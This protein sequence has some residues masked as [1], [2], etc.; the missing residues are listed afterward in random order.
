MRMKKLLTLLLVLILSLSVLLTLVACGGGDGDG[1]N[2]G[3]NTANGGNPS[4]DNGGNTGGNTGGST[5]G[6]DNGGST[7][8]EGGGSTGGEGGS[9]GGGSEGGTDYSEFL[10]EDGELILFNSGM[11]TFKF[12]VA[13]DAA[14]VRQDVDTLASTLSGL[15]T[16]TVKVENAASSTVE[17]VEILIG[18]VNNR[19]DEYKYNKYDLGMQGYVVK[20]VGSKIIVQGG[21]TEALA[22]AIN[23]LKS[24]VFGLKK[25]NDDFEDFAMANATNKEFVQSGYDVTSI[26][27]AGDTIKNYTITY[28]NNTQK[29]YATELQNRLYSECG[30]HLDTSRDASATGKK[31]AILAATNTGIGDGF[32][33][34]VDEN[35]NLTIICEIAIRYEE[36][37]NSF[38]NNFIFDQKDT[39]TFAENFDYSENIRKIY[40][41]KAMNTFED[42]PDI[43]ATG[44]GTTDDFFALKA[45]HDY[46]NQHLLDVHADPNATYYI[47]NANGYQ[48]IS[49][50]TSTY[51]NAC[52]FIFDDE[53]VR[54]DVYNERAASIFKIER[55]E[56]SKS[57]Y[58]DHETSPTPFNYLE[59]GAT[60]IGWAPGYTALI[61]LENS[62]QKRYNR[63]GA[64]ADGGQI[65][66]E[67]IVVDAEGNI[68]PST[69]V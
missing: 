41:N 45:I 30:I 64:N 26:I 44:S 6:G 32:S 13:S 53:N 19:G 36:T 54:Y 11:P 67:I 69:P 65:Q 33:A 14:Q 29:T 10:N 9:E 34:K 48:S 51:F 47:G 49:V 3:D 63:F 25:T 55:D 40:Y 7:G 66:T 17:A 8:G 21:S 46:A 12:I 15:G 27:I 31:I 56:A 4:G 5:G 18:S 59:S 24:T 38:L 62:N 22:T 37:L 43:A 35:G 58:K 20:Q 57:Y 42:D 60:N 61:I 39:A 52:T 2:A 1:D 50:K 68:D 16:K 28:D 23:Y